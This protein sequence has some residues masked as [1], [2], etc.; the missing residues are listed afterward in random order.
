[1]IAGK[2]LWAID[3]FNSA[4]TERVKTLLE[5]WH[6]DIVQIEF[7]IMG[8]YL[9]ALMDYPAPR[10]LVQHEPGEETARELIRSPYAP[11][12]IMPQLDL[13]AWKRFEGEV[14]QQVQAVVVFTERDRQAVDKAGP[15][16]PVVRIP[17]GTEIPE[18]SLNQAGEEPLS[19]LF[20]GNFE[21]LPNVDAA[22]R[23][24]TEIFPVVRARFPESL[25]YIVGSNPPPKIQRLAS[26]NVL[27]TGYV[28]DLTSFLDRAA[29]CIVPLRM[30]G[31][32]RVKVLEALANG[33]AV[34]AS[35]LAVQGLD[36]EDGRQ[37]V[38]AE[39]DQ[40]FSKAAIHLLSTPD[41]RARLASA[42][43]AW[44][45]AN[46]SWEKTVSSYEDLYA[47]LLKEDCATQFVP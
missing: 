28:P 22:H 23:L 14:I 47:R 9:S 41:L 8:Q 10:I 11:G 21:H 2:P 19:L 27:V 38:L 25:L 34:I 16:V 35:S 42:A 12:R 18:R 32:M 37:V 45:C 7:H 5:T 33:K 4:Y 26:E 43:Y 15:H 36:L 31:G 29:L 46:L 44:A 1:L 30:G 6:P 13:L 17:F 40:E 3:R 39:S 20:V 24:I